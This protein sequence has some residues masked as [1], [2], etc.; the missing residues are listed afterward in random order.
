MRLRLA[1]FF[2]VPCLITA[3]FAAAQTPS[4]GRPTIQISRVPTP[5]HLDDY[6]EGGTHP[7][8]PVTDFRQR[9]PKDL[10]PITQPTTAYLSYDDT[11]LYVGFVCHASSVSEVRAHMSKR[12]SVFSDDVIG[13]LIDTFRDQQRAYMFFVNPLG[14]QAD[15]ITA[16]A[17]GDDMSFDTQWHSEGKVTSSG[18]VVLVAIPFKSLRFPVQTNGAQS[19]RLALMRIM[20]ATD[21]QAFWPGITNKLNNFVAQFGDLEG[22]AGVSPGRNLQLI[23]YATF[24]RA[25]E[26]DSKNARYASQNE[27]RAGLDVKTVVRDALTLDF[28]LNP[29]FS[30]VESDDPQV[31]VNQRFEVFF[32]EKRPFFLENA[33]YFND[34]PQNLFF[35]RRIADPQFGG[36]V[37]GKLGHWA[38]GAVAADDRAPGRRTDP[39]SPGH[40]DRTLDG[41]F[42]VR[43]DFG[44]QSRL[45]AML[46]TRTFG[47]SSNT[48]A[49]ADTRIRIN[50][51]WF[52]DAQTVHSDT[53]ALDGSELKGTLTRVQLGRS[54][55]EFAY[56]LSY[57]DASPGFR[58]Q[59]G[60]VPRLDYRQVT[61]YFQIRWFPK[62]GPVLNYGPN[63]FSQATWNYDGALRDWVARLPFLVVFKGR[64]NVFVRHAFISETIQGRVFRQ[65]EDLV[66]FN[67]D[68]LK[69]FGVNTAFNAS[70]RP[71]Y[72]PAPGLVPFLGNSTELFLGLTLQPTSALRF[73]E[74]YFYTRLTARPDSPGAGR[75]F[76]NPIVRSRVNY[77][78]SREWSL[79]AIVDYSALDPNE[80]LVAFARS[81]HVSNDLL[82]T[83]LAHPGTAIYIGYTDGYDNVHLDPR[84]SVVPTPRALSSTGR[85]VFVKASWLFR[86]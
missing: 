32:P 11:Q 37:T 72:Y 28:T 26:L 24:A 71:N 39:G 12:E 5:P 54:G 85:Q 50:P 61:N 23:P 52:I 20:P 58:T 34:T 33:D 14:V 49:S 36:R 59:L 16:A 42:R 13:V 1:I 29:D 66:A 84:D 56:N 2:V 9:Q 10:E 64:T 15:G 19:W 79:R 38:F 22:L 73:E 7:G 44:S 63:S 46:T 21:E 30:Q 83:W 48:V 51:Q 43:H 57:E 27:H 4:P 8:A 70:T 77:Q 67:S 69:W 25:R 17:T 65:R 76:T 40:G 35:S 6:L 80:Q 74:T 86:F 78:F 81:R 41:V 18:Y 75:V 45:G 47:P 53:T 31:T 55:R 82:L 3:S 68:Y 60:F 62:T